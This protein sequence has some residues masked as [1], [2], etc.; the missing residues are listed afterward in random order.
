MLL[1]WIELDTFSDFFTEKHREHLLAFRQNNVNIR[2]FTTILLL[3]FS[4]QVGCGLFK[5]WRNKN[6]KINKLII[7]L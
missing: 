2:I 4:D 7:Y 3:N 5:Y 6:L 1:S